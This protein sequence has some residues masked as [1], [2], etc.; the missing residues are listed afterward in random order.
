MSTDFPVLAAAQTR[1]AGSRNAFAARLS[2]AGTS[3]VFSTFL[4]GNGTDNGNGVALDGTGNIYVAGDTTS[5]N[6]PTVN[7]MQKSLAGQQ[8]AFVTK[9][10]PSGAIVYSTYFGGS[11]AD[12]AAGIAVDDG[13]SAYIAG[14]TWSLNLPVASAL[15][16]ANG[17]GQD[18]FAAKLNAPGSRVALQATLSGRQ[19]R[20]QLLSGD[21][22][23]NSGGWVR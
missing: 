1:L 12:S 3:L 17:G 9:F 15:Q 11:A 13:G 6:F 5:T 23:W 10:S 19:R 16:T 14:G 21:R 8:D 22:H 18:A 20:K 7:A 4:G 2:P